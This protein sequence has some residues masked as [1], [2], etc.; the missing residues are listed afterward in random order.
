MINEMVT[1]T[2][3]SIDDMSIIDKLTDSHMTTKIMC[4]VSSVSGVVATC[5][6]NRVN[7]DCCLT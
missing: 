2:S 1:V 6:R 4:G 5:F 7:S 3:D